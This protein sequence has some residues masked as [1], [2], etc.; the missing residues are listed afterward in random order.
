MIKTI[1]GP[2]ELEKNLQSSK[3]AFYGATHST[4]SSISTD[5]SL[6][7]GHSL[8]CFS[9]DTRGVSCRTLVSFVT[10]NRERIVFVLRNIIPFSWRLS[11]VLLV[12]LVMF[13][14]NGVVMSAAPQVSFDCSTSGP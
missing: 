6:G 2:S 3:E 11:K 1:S 12:A 7:S 14:E 9:A 4:E 10:Y 5:L 8:H 13:L